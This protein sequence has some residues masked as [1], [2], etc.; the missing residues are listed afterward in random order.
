MAPNWFRSH[1]TSMW[2]ICCLKTAPEASMFGHLASPPKKKKKHHHH[3]LR[4]H[5]DV[6]VGSV[7]AGCPISSSPLENTSLYIPEGVRPGWRERNG[8]SAGSGTRRRACWHRWPPE[9]VGCKAGQGARLL[10]PQACAGHP[11]GGH[12]LPAA[13]RSSAGSSVVPRLTESLK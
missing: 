3:L 4:A 6:L 7:A 5:E 11:S 10:L 8:R 2:R 1:P 13:D 12:W 9:W